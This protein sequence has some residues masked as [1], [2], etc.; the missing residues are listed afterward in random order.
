MQG[1]ARLVGQ[2]AGAVIMTM[3]LS[4][5]SLESAPRIGLAVA[6]VLT[7]AGGLVSVLLVGRG[8]ASA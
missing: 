7:L 2:T 1:T 4:R 5:V 6:A 8:L 3:L